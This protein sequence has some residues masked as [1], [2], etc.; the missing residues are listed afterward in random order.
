MRAE[1][2]EADGSPAAGNHTYAG[3]VPTNPIPTPPQAQSEVLQYQDRTLEGAGGALQYRDKP[4]GVNRE[5]SE[6]HTGQR[7]A[8]ETECLKRQLLEV[9]SDQESAVDIILNCNPTVRDVN[10]LSEMILGFEM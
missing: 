4:A 1:K 3:R 6:G 5:V 7:R 10:K 2:R 8:Q 9:F